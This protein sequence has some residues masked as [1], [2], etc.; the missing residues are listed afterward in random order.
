MNGS[1]VPTEKKRNSTNVF[2]TIYRSVQRLAGGC[3]D[4]K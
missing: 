2:L 4:D 1:G 3:K